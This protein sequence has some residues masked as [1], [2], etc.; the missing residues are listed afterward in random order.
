MGS[1]ASADE[2]ALLK[3]QLEALQSRI[4]HIEPPPATS[5]SGLVTIERGQ[6]SL[7]GWGQDSRNRIGNNPDTGFTLAI[8][9]TADV[10]APVAEI[11]VYGYVKGD[12]IFDSSGMTNKYSFSLLSLAP[13][14]AEGTYGDAYVNLHAFQTRFGIKSLVDTS[15]GQIRTRIEGDFFGNGSQGGKGDLRLRQAYGEWDMAPG[16]ALLVGQTDYLENVTNIG[17]PFVD[18]FEEAG[19][20]G[21]SRVPQVRL[22]YKDG[23]LTW[24]VAAEDPTWDSATAVPNIAAFFG[25]AGEEGVTFQLT[26]VISDYSVDEEVGTFNSSTV[27]QCTGPAAGATIIGYDAEGN[28]VYDAVS[29]ECAVLTTQGSDPDGL[30]WAVMAGASV[31]LT[32]A[33]EVNAGANYGQGEVVPQ[34]NQTATKN[35]RVDADGDLMEAWSVQTG[36]SFSVSEAISLNIGAGY[37]EY[38]GALA[39]EGWIESAATVHA[40]VLWQP[41]RYMRL[42]WEVMWGEISYAGEGLC[43]SVEAV[44]ITDGAGAV[45]GSEIDYSGCKSSLDDV[46]L[47][48]GAWFF[49]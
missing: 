22:T 15:V 29:T 2:L 45:I 20:L 5:N 3:A 35:Q 16:W 18:F 13:A 17:I 25:Y 1:V 34:L 40:N 41:V 33:V 39:E 30:G 42:G 27:G 49:F 8:T 7:G 43:R 21:R 47:Q 10:P 11:V 32:D 19:P 38:L 36:L 48:F 37:E 6:G 14:Y 28:A 46:R 26:G 12:V 31:A 24:A 23:P 9:P 44:D 4:D